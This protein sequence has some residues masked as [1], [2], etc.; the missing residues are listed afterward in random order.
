MTQQWYLVGQSLFCFGRC[1]VQ[2]SC[3]ALSCTVPTMHGVSKLSGEAEPSC[4]LNKGSDQSSHA[5]PCTPSHP[6]SAP[7]NGSG[8][9]TGGIA[10]PP[11]PEPKPEAGPSRRLSEHDRVN[12]TNALELLQSGAFKLVPGKDT[13]PYEKLMGL[14]LEDGIDVTRKVG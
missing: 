10:Q 11:P 13:V 7:Q 4:F 2:L 3:I 14:R 12:N 8:V 6:F 5:L 1:P 9:L